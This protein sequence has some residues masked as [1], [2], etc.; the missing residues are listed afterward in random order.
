M[1]K[2][3]LQSAALVAALVIG[4]THAAPILT[5]DPAA[6]ALTGAP[7]SLVGWGFTITNTSDFLIVTS[8]DF[9]PLSSLGTFTDFIGPNFIIV[10]PAPESPSVSQAFDAGLLTGIG[11]FAINPSALIG[12]LASGLITLTYDLYSLSPNDPNFDPISDGISFGN[13]LTADA[14]V[15]VGNG[16][17]IPEPGSLAL[18]VLALVVLGCCRRT[19]LGPSGA[20]A[21][22]G[23]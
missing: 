22:L 6:G 13:L 12:S 23:A 18:V 9:S 7:G 1:L 20:V 8:A 11:S 10:G 17:P 15:R 14:S 3:F 21:L 5:L 16:N 2:Q 4:G 19:R